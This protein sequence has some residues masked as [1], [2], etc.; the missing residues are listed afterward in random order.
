MAQVALD[1]VRSA[2]ATARNAE[3]TSSSS[4]RAPLP[5]TAPAPINDPDGLLSGGGKPAATTWA[6]PSSQG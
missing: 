6:D 2:E 4:T 5:S 1:G 3:A